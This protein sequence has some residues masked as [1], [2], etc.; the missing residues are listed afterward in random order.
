MTTTALINDNAMMT[1]NLLACTNRIVCIPLSSLMP[2]TGQ[3]FFLACEFGF[4]ASIKSILK[5]ASILAAGQCVWTF[6]RIFHIK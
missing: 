3:R 6:K 5:Q 1:P 4:I 2:T